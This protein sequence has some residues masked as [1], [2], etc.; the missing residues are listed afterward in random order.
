[1]SF[2]RGSEWRKWDLHVHTPYSYLNNQ[3]GN[4]FDD[5]VKQLFLNAISHQIAVIGVTDYFSIEGYKKIRKEYLD[6]D[7]KLKSL[8]TDEQ[9]NQIKTIKIIPNIEFRLNKIVV[10][11]RVNFHV[12]FSD[13]VLIEDIEE[14]F[15]HEL[16]FIYEGNPQN[17]D[18]K[19]KLK[20]LNIENLGKKLIAEQPELGENPLFVGLKCAVVDDTQVLDILNNKQSKFKNK[21]LVV[22]PADEDLSAINWKSQDHNVRKVILQKADMLFASN[23][24]TI[25]WG[26]GEFNETI[27]DYIKEFKSVKVCIWGSDA[28]GYDNLFKPANN[29]FTWIKANPTFEGLKQVI[30]EPKDRVYI[31]EIPSK[32]RLVNSNK[33]KFIEKIEINK[34]STSQLADK[35]FENTNPIPLNSDLIAIIGNKGNGK[36]ALADIIALSGNVKLPA[37]DWFSFLNK[38][39]F[40]DNKSLATNFESKLTWMNHTGEAVNLNASTPEASIEKVKYLPQKYIEKIC[41]EDEYN[42]FQDEI[43]TVVFSHIK[44]EDRLEKHNLKDLIRIKTEVVSNERENLLKD[45]K[46]LL[47][48]NEDLKIKYSATEQKK[49]ENLL[50]EKNQQ[51]VDHNQNKQLIVEVKDPTTSEEVQ[52]EIK[53]KFEESKKILTQ[54][55]DLQKELITIQNLLNSESI[56][57]NTIEVVAGE[58]D[59]LYSQFS[60]SMEEKQ[61]KLRDCGLEIDI[62]K[63][64]EIHYEK[65][66]LAEELEKIKKLIS[67]NNVLKEKKT[68]EVYTL[69]ESRTKLDSELSEPQ[70]EYQDYLEKIKLWEVKYIELI[71]DK[72]VIE[73]E[74]D[75][76]KTEL[77]TKL[78][79]YETR[80]IDLIAEIYNTYNKELEIFKELYSSVLEFVSQ[81]K[82]KLGSESFINFTT[83]IIIDKKI[84]INS[85]VAFFDGRRQQFQDADLK[86]LVAKYS[87]DTRLD[88][89][90]EMFTELIDLIEKDKRPLNQQFRDGKQL[91]D[92]YLELFGLKYLKVEYDI[93]FGGKNV[94]QLSPGE[95]GALL[96]LF[97]LLIDKGDI[98]LIIDQPEDNLDN[99]SV[100]EYLVPY[101]KQA[102]QRRQIIIVT[103]NPNI[104]VVADAE[105]IIYTE[106]DKANGNQIKYITGAIEDKQINKEIVKVLEGTMPAFDNRTI[107]YY[108]D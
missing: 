70:R 103:H 89:V 46:Q 45:L 97:S 76:S 60:K 58:I 16:E 68:Q 67:N 65:S 17:S 107:K 62:S 9:I 78:S 40:K 18:E 56:K 94:R 101:I 81:E 93:L 37:G 7:I 41:S 39:R 29:R 34:I 32:L 42:S 95:R 5:Y 25:K 74:I 61:S 79:E 64:F 26:L 36:S 92:F 100:F 12:I 21:Y 59:I 73:K 66:I 49:L 38:K 3:F 13:E 55:D 96:I 75:F 27:D 23:S 24:K 105:Q 77:P 54:I 57:K 108:R 53:I 87:D 10:T 51:I 86:E 48:D 43:N 31:G 30:N 44:Q 106:L 35:W 72:T 11:N 85:L 63:V 52:G 98:P 19:W 84:L 14:N 22:V 82:E 102:K 83:Q 15:L 71:V 1:M 6:N 69:S 8:F 20:R 104:A 80:K 28:H 2:S 99:E 90:K 50:A 33:D 4:D 88:N 91:I 47:Q